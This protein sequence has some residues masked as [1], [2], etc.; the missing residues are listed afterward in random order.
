MLVFL[1]ILHSPFTN[2]EDV[3]LHN[4]S[5]PHPSGNVGTLINKI[6]PV[7]KGEVVWT[8]SPQDLSDNWRAAF[9]RKFNAERIVL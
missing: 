2:L 8:V 3:V 9:N 5:G 4:V 1:K 6:D 7:N